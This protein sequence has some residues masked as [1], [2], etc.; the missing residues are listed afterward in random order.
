M[1]E[2]ENN[3]AERIGKLE[4]AFSALATD[5]RDIKRI[6][7]DIGKPNLSNWIAAGSFILAFGVVIYG[8][9]IHPLNQDI[10]RHEMAADK[11]ALAVISQD[12][13]T[14]KMEND[15]V[16]LSDRQLTVMETLKRFDSEGSAAADK[17]L[18]LLEYQMKLLNKNAKE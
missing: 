16:R 15:I 7:S 13:K 14:S 12:V 5:V 3:H 17:R 18:M 10:A 6:V 4:T 9:A 8:A 11:L 2:Q 1:S